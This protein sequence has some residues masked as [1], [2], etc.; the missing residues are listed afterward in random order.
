MALQKWDR[1]NQYQ[2][3]FDDQLFSSGESIFVAAGPPR[4]A[5]IGGSIAAA[6]QLNQGSEQFARR[7]GFIQRKMLC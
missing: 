2:E 6:A 4:L 1:Y 7:I 3:S 5:S